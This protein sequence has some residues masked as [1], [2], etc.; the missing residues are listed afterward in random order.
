MIRYYQGDLLSVKNG[1]IL[2]GVNCQRKMASGVAKAIREAYPQVYDS[3]MDISKEEMLEWIGRIQLVKI[4][5]S[6]TI[7]NAF[8]QK[9]YGYDGKLYLSYDA[10]FDCF[11]QLGQLNFKSVHIPKIGCGLA[12]GDWEIVENLIQRAAPSVE[13]NVWQL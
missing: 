3:Y 1:L 10:L 9:Y 8:T 7:G 13:I 11:T 5:D 4:D 12:G 2:H 6:L